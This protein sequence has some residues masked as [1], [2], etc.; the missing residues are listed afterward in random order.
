MY[1]MADNNVRTA[2]VVQIPVCGV[3]E[4]RKNWIQ[5]SSGFKTNRGPNYPCDD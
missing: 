3:A 4:A 5:Y 2:G 1:S